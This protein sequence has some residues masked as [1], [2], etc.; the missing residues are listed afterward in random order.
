MKYNILKQI[1]EYLQNYKK[2]NFIKRVGNTKFLLNFD[3]KQALIFD[4]D[5]TNSSIYKEEN[6]LE[7]KNFQAPFDVALQKRFTNSKIEK[8]EVLP[9]NRILKISVI[10]EGSYKREESVLYFEFTGRFTNVILCDENGFIVDALRH[11]SNEV[12][13][14]KV[15][16][17]FVE[18]PAFEIKEKASPIIED[19][20]LYFREEFEKINGKKLLELKKN[21]ILQ[22]DKKILLLEKTLASLES[23]EN[24]EEKSRILN[25][26]A[27]IIMANLYKIKDFE[28]EVT[29]LDFNGEEIKISMKESAKLEANSLFKEAK[30]AK[31]KA[32]NLFLEAKNL[33]EKLSYYLGLKKMIEDSKNLEEIRVLLPKKSQ[34]KQDKLES[35]VL[36]SFYIKDFKISVGKNEKGNILLLKNSK[37]DDF[38]F[39]LKD[40]PSAHV[41]VKTNR[42]KLSE[43]IINFAAKLCLSFS[44]KSSGKYEVAYTKRSNVKVVDKAF[45]NYVDYKI[46]S[47]DIEF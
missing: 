44:V 27:K 2:I 25:E 32:N 29:L 46:V 16:K 38:W 28:R 47:V 15:G 36:S 39:H 17:K 42:Q 12:R 24:L 10:K 7:S 45:V 43:E 31:Q 8:L 33:E 11:F 5:K 30:K 1:A 6:L 23:K 37:K 3:G 9:N 26:R 41:I 40:L 35:E 4:L 14:I 13:E 18:L 22:L 19:F 34:N 20:E 21:K